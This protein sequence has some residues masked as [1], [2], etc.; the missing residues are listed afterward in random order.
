MSIVSFQFLLFLFIGCIVYYVVPKKVQWVVLLVLSFFF[1]LRGGAGTVIY[2][3]F[4]TVTVW[5]AGALLENVN[6]KSKKQLKEAIP[7]LTKE[8]KKKIKSKAKKQKKIIFWSTLLVNFGILAYLKYANFFVNNFLCWL[9]MS[10]TNVLPQMSDVIL[11]LG[12]SFYTFQSIGYLIDIY[13]ERIKAERNLFR[14]SLFVSFFPQVIQGPISRYSQLGTQFYQEH[15]FEIEKIERAAMLMLWGY[16]KKMVISNRA[17]SVVEATFE[18][19][20]NYA[21]TF[22]VFGVFMYSL[23]QYADF[24]GGIDIITGAAELFD[25]KLTKNFKRPYFSVSLS[26]FWRRWHISLGAWMRDYIFYPLAT[27]KIMGTIRK[28]IKN[29]WGEQAAKA[30]IGTICN[31]V[32]F[33]IVG[34]WHGAYWHFVVWGLYN[35]VVISISLLMEPIFIKMKSCFGNPDFFKSSVYRVFCI[36]RTFLIVNFGWFFDRAGLINSFLMIKKSFTD[37][38]IAN[39][40]VGNL[41]ET[42]DFLPRD[43]FFLALSSFIIFIVSYYQEKDERSVRD[44]LLKK[45]LAIRW[46]VIYAFLVFFVMG[47]MLV[48]GSKGDFMYAQY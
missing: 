9:Q 27:T 42:F 44:Y 48:E 10:D 13:W 14:F 16:F 39:L 23:Q 1:Y 43:F 31:I 26:D 41:C 4:T 19:P 5:G 18:H 12:I 29:A 6:E 38:H 15:Y 3:V 30:L 28:K 2:I 33:F 25:I 11:P 40:S 46:M 24:S 34:I 37:F 32:I 22:I 36:L 8:E 45:P 20:E 47:V 21:G 17:I 7:E 35:G